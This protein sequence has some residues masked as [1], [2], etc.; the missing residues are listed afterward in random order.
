M[1]DIV[2]DITPEIRRYIDMDTIRSHL[3]QHGVI[4]PNTLGKLTQMDKIAQCDFLL[5]ILC[6]SGGEGLQ[7]FGKALKETSSGHAGHHDI[8]KKLK[9]NVGFQQLRKS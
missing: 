5:T 4:D 1:E 3:F 8:L 6:R 7:K 9:K 2:R